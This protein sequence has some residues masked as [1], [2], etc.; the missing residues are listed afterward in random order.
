MGK[1]RLLGPV[2]GVSLAAVALSTV[3]GCGPSGPKIQVTAAS[4]GYAGERKDVKVDVA[5]YCD[6]KT[7]CTFPVKNETFSSKEPLDPSP[8][9]DKGLMVFWK[10]NDV[11]HKTQFAEG[12]NAVVDCN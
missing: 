5:K 1:K 7:S 2:L 8:G 6:D 3:G 9:N 10:C 11:A 12:R 4:W